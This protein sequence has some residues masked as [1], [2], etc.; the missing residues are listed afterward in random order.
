MAFHSD[1]LNSYAFGNA[2]DRLMVDVFF[3]QIATG[4]SSPERDC[5][6]AIFIF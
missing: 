1:D 3:F 4:V 2:E 6:M 5:L